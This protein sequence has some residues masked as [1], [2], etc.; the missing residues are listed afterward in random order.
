MADLK[1]FWQLS[2]KDIFHLLNTHPQGLTRHQAARRLKEARK[3][4]LSQ[5]RKLHPL[6]LLLSQFNN[7]LIYI[8]I[9]VVILSLFFQN[10]MDAVI[11]LIIIF[12][13]GILSFI[14]EKKAASAVNELLAIVKSKIEVLRDGKK[15]EIDSSDVVHGD[16]I[17][18]SAGDMIP[19]DC[20]LLEAKDFHVDESTLTGETFPIEKKVGLASEAARLS[21][22]RNSLF[23]GTHVVSGSAIAV[24]VLVGKE[25]E[26]GKIAEHLRFKP[27]ET[28][29]ERGV[30][31]F[32][33]FLLEVTLMLVIL[34]FALNMYFGR[35]WIES[36]LFALALAVGLTPQLLPAIITINLSYGAKQ[37]AEKKVIVRK[38]DSIEN[39]GSMDVLCVDKTGTLTVGSMK[40]TR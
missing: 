24:V 14:Q 32:G 7:P 13:S 35:A 8:L 15:I 36:L 29:F 18:L 19:G 20:Y 11:I 6:L 30:R 33:Y 5:K 10:R 25:T 40:L 2:E 26:F 1:S 34:I 28:S 39:F 22:R 16:I 17:Y 23:M 12:G 37:M 27:P 21:D 4:S 38:L 31:H 9:A 3:N